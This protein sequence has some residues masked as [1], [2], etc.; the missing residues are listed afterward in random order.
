MSPCTISNS[1]TWGRPCKRC[2]YIRWEGLPA[3]RYA[4]CDG[5]EKTADKEIDLARWRKLGRPD[6]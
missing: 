5:M 1:G 2:G 4:K 3:Y 6:A